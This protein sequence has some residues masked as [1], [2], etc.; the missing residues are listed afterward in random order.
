LTHVDVVDP[1]EPER[2]QGLHDLDAC[3]L[4]ALLRR[5]DVSP[6]EL[7]DNAL[8]RIDR[9]NPSVGAFISVR[10]ERAR[11]EARA[12]AQR[13]AAGDPAPLLGVPTA[14]K[15]SWPTKGE[16]TTLGVPHLLGW[17]PDFD[18]DV[19]VALRQAGTISVGKTAVPEFALSG[20]TEPSTA[21][22]GRTPY[23]LTRSAGGSSGG[24][25]AAV[26]ARLVPVAQG[27]DTGGSIRAPAS[28]C[29]LVG[30]KPS[31][32]RTSCGPVGSDI[33]GMT[34][35]G[36]LSRTVADT[37]AF[38]DVLAGA[39]ADD[40]YALPPLAPQ[41]CAA[42]L[43]EALPPLRVARYTRPFAG[44]PVH[45]AAVASTEMTAGL[46]SD[47]GHEVVDVDGPFDERFVDAFL[48]VYAALAA[49]ISVPPAAEQGLQPGTRALRQRGARMSAAEGF[50]AVGV[51][52][53][54][55]AEALARVAGF[56]L[57]LSPTTPEL[58]PVVGSLERDD[59]WE[60]IGLLVAYAGFT[61]PMNATG[62]PAVS[63]PVATT[64]SGLPV[65]VQLAGA[66]GAEPL[67]LSVAA[68]LEERVRWDL[69]RPAL[70]D[71]EMRP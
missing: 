2:A 51:L 19:V 11:A 1:R 33:V 30:L 69:R 70:I 63:L 55:A 47:M 20:I 64:E 36:V 59:P 23:D 17:E 38:L 25:A 12:A 56:D 68:R 67:L 40:P 26:A 31:R 45:A 44:G 14:I 37:A 10:P 61:A 60:S 39:A 48:S 15:D 57:L 66:I 53:G 22:P 35:V 8:E 58:A 7:V 18:A 4:V 49:Q 71:E 32:G 54:L 9:L 21:P 34:T 50:V 62:Q 41:A 3:T 5:G 16:V 52:R 6:L 46:L 29:G 13:L 27:G 65:G 24:A 42:A 28:Y 43:T